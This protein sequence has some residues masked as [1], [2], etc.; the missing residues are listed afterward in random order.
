M[1]FF[2]IIWFPF[3]LLHNRL[4]KKRRGS[5]DSNEPYIDKK[6]NLFKRGLD[7]IRGNAYFQLQDKMEKARVAR[8]NRLNSI[9]EQG[10]GFQFA[11]ASRSMFGALLLVIFLA[12]V[13]DFSISWNLNTLAQQGKDIKILTSLP[14]E[15]RIP[16]IDLKLPTIDFIQTFI[17]VAIAAISTILGLIFALYAVGI[18]L[19]TQTYSSEVSDYINNER[20]GNFFFKLLIFT[21]LFLLYILIEI[22]LINIYPGASFLIA[23]ILITLSVLGVLVFKNSYILSLKPKG[24]FGRMLGET[25]KYITIATNRKSFAY[26][27]ASAIFHAKTGLRKTI[28]LIGIFFE[29]LKRAGNWN[30]AVY[31]PLVLSQVLVNYISKRK[32]IDTERGWW[33]FS[34]HKEV[35]GNDSISLVLKLNYELKGTGPLNIPTPDTNWVEDEILSWFKQFNQEVDG[36]KEKEKFVLQLI[37]AYQA[38]LFGEYEK[39]KNGHYKKTTIGAYGNQE[40]YIFNIFLNSFLDLFNKIDQNNEE[41]MSAYTM[42]FFAV[43]QSVIDGFEYDQIEKAISSMIGSDLKLGV[44]KEEVKRLDFPSKFYHKLND[45]YERLEV[46][47]HL[48]GQIITPKEFLVREIIDGLKEEE[49]S[50]FIKQIDRLTK[51]QEQMALVLY[52][53]KNFKSLAQ[54]VRS[55]LEWFARLLYLN[56]YDL[57]EKYADVIPKLGVYIGLMP[58]D[59]LVEVDFQLQI[60]RMIFTACME[61]KPKLFDHLLRSLLLNLLTLNDGT[62]LTDKTQQAQWIKRNRILVILGG[63]VYLVS[64]FEQKQNILVDYV[65]T[66]EKVF[67]E[68]FFAKIVDALADVKGLGLNMHLQLINSETSRYHFWFGQMHHKIDQLP[69]TYDDIEHYSGMQEVADHPSKFIR[70]ISFDLHFLEESIIESFSEWVQKREAVKELIK[71]LKSK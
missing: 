21:D 47:Q 58:K 70:E 18:Q 57:A 8:Y 27:S 25:D 20:V 69:K 4:F 61:N 55:R 38:I 29:D 23:L 33:F 6:P 1:T 51:F 9:E 5:G 40:F 7:Q 12:F 17:G 64:Q 67:K 52:K 10:L 56:K 66:V 24:P 45:Y 41:I 62:D 60:E 53:N 15:Y 14:L 54:L 65:N 43:C 59:I 32:Y 13:I 22:N 36:N 35:K 46:E 48:E 44:K 49:T 19:T 71:I 16:I 42:T 68:G 11:S 31:A 34:R 50:E 26:R 3:H 63:F 39:D 37:S 30:D 28:G 2:R